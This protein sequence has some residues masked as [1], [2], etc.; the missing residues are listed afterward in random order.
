MLPGHPDIDINL[1]HGGENTAVV[2]NDA[3]IASRRAYLADASPLDGGYAR[4]ALTFASVAA[5]AVFS[6][7]R[8]RMRRAQSTPPGSSTK[9]ASVV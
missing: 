2:M 1:S 3:S 9:R 6:L 4:M 5:C 8:R 7:R